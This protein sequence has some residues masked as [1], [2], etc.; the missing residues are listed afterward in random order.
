MIFKPV[1]GINDQSQRNCPI[2]CTS[3]ILKIR[4]SLIQAN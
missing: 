4:A 2:A 1:L 3:S